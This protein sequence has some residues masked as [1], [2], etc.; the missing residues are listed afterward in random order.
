MP[1][2]AFIHTLGVVEVL[3][4]APDDHVRVRPKGSRHEHVVRSSLL[5][6]LDCK[7]AKEARLR[8]L[9]AMQFRRAKRSAE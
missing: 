7:A 9:R 5:Q 3:G 1:E 2:L 4:S 6:P 8:Q